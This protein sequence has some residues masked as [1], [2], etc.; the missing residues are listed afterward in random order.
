MFGCDEDWVDIWPAIWEAVRPVSLDPSPMK[1]LA[2]ALPVTV[3]L[4]RFPTDVMFG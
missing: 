3:K 2:T 1:V 4:A